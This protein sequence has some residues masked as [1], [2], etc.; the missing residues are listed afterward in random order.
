M[1]ILATELKEQGRLVPDAVVVTV[2]SNQGFH[3][4][5][6]E[7]GIEVIE[8]PVGDKHVRGDA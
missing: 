1:T 4:A 5:M 3:V 8:T 7:A 6:R 2:M